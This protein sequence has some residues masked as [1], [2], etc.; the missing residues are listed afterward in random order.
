MMRRFD[1]DANMTRPS[2]SAALLIAA[3]TVAPVVADEGMWT[4]DNPPLAQLKQKYGFEPTKEWLDKVRAAS[5]RFMDG[6]SGSFVS[7]DGLMITNHHVGLGCIQNVSSP[8]SDFVKSGFYAPTR[9]EEAAC[10]GYEVNVLQ[11]TEDVTA[12]VQGTVAPEM[13]DAQAREARKAASAGIENECTKATGLR[14][15]VVTLYQG[16]EFHLYRYR[17]Y[18]DVRLVF[19][20]EQGIAFFGGDPDNFTFPRHDLDICLMRAYEGG[21]PVP[22]ASYLRWTAKGVGDGDLVFVS[23]HPGS[24][25]RA[26]TTARLEYLR[27][28]AW[29]FRLEMY[30]R[31]LTALRSY[32]ALGEEQKR[33]ALDQIFGYEN[34]QKAIGGY[35][36]ALLDAKAMARKAE[37]EKALRAKVAAD[38]ALAQRVGDPWATVAA[39]QQKVA[40]RAMDVRLV[41]FDGSQL[42]GIAG[43]IVQY[44]AEVEKPNEKRYEEYVDANLDSLRNALLSPAPIHAD[45][46][47]VTLADQLQLA[48]DK[49]GPDHAFVKAALGGTTPAEAAKA[50]VMGTKLQDPAARKALLDGGVAAVSASADP[51]IVLARRIDPLAREVRKFL[52]DEVDAPT[53]RAM[54][55][56]AQ[57]RWKVHG[58][59]VPPDATFTLRLSFGTVKGFPAEGTT[60]A[61]FT[62]F[63]GL[64]DRSLSHGGKEPWALPAR[65]RE[66]LSALDGSVPLNFVST[67][68]II[69][70]NSG[71]PVVD[72]A[73]DFVGIVFDGNIHSLAWDYY[74][75]DEQGRSV[76]VD[77]RAILEALGKVYGA[78]ALVRELT[79]R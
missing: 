58:R 37:E 28:R 18:T 49:L 64:F 44:V 78:D 1:G 19:A 42:L 33:R 6:G 32:A 20:P 27:D 23:G 4:Y 38:P 25:S 34:S 72:R 3:F 21:K 26:D 48:F 51:M 46:E 61:P 8:E 35:H 12:R 53:T 50:A 56:I 63:Y 45:L 40:S 30:K 65:W 10:P 2:A 73:G 67:N 74:F 66:R 11:S 79:V 7:P 9:E 24:T 60:V 62:T 77:A 69:G 75:T 15:N 55:K 54:E 29:P 39:I 47:A 57:A 36:A 41:G 76:S 52:E 71:S 13:T 43:Q 68:D 14:C 16:G 31:R 17:K 70:G 22:S 5:V 59:T